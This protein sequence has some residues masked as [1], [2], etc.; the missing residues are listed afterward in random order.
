MLKYLKSVL[1][2]LYP[3]LCFSCSQYEPVHDG[4]LCHACW[5]EIPPFSDVSSN[6][7]L[8]E[9]KFPL[10]YHNE[11]AF[12]GLFLFTKKGGVQHILHQLKYNG[13]SYIGIQLGKQIGIQI[14]SEK[15]DALVPVPM[16]YKKRRR[17]GYNQ[18]E[19]IAKGISEQTGIPI[20]NNL[21]E[22]EID[23]ASQTKKDRTNRHTNVQKAY[24]RKNRVP[25]NVKSVLL[26][27]DVITTG[28]TLDVCS[29]ILKQQGGINVDFGFIAMTFSS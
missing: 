3:Q 28:A 4:I 23:I 17:R 12:Y 22:K 7:V 25:P 27:D 15:Y 2:L 5:K 1:S 10:L 14:P 20:F 11:T 6:R 18:A 8:L 24:K 21:L 26:I 16:H 9:Q 13:K 29:S 19:V